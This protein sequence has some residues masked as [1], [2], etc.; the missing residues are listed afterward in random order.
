MAFPQD[1]KSWEAQ[2]ARLIS[3]AW[4]DEA[5]YNRLLNDPAATLRDNGLILEDFVEVQVNQAPNAVPVLRGTEGERV[6]YEMPLPPKPDDLK[7]EQ[8]PFGLE[9]GGDIPPDMLPKC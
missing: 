7:E 6:I 8:I 5:L 4:L 2:I 3:Q 9:Q 1:W